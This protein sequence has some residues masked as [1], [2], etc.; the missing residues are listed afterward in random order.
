MRTIAGLKAARARGRIDGIA[1]GLSKRETK[2]NMDVEMVYKESELT[3]PEICCQLGISKP[4]F[5]R[6]LRFRRVQLK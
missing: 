1:K 3:I 2:Q 6:F 5:Y 4:T